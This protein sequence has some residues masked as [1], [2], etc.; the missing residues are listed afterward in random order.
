MIPRAAALGFLGAAMLVAGCRASRRGPE[1]EPRPAPRTPV[2]TG[3]RP[4]APPDTASLRALADS[5]RRA[6]ERAESLLVG[7]PGGQ[8]GTTPGAPA[9]A[10]SEAPAQRCVLDLENRDGTGAMMVKNPV[11]GR[12]YTVIGGGVV[13]R[14]RGQ[15]VTI[16]ADS[17]E[18]YEDSRLYLLIGNVKYREPKLALDAQRATYFRAEERILLENAVHA[19]MLQGGGTLDGSRAEYWRPARGIRER[20]RLVAYNR[21]RLT[22]VEHDSAGRPLPPVLL[23]ADVIIGEGDSTFFGIGQVEITRQDIFARAD[24]AMMDGNRQFSRLMKKPMIE[25]RGAQPYTLRGEV[26]DLFGSARQVERVVAK[27]SARAESKQFTVQSDTIDL[28]VQGSRLNRAFAFGSAGAIATTPE[29]NIVADSLDIIMP[30]QRIRELRAIGKA[31]AESDPDSTKVRSVERDWL[32]GDTVIARFDSVAAGDT[33]RPALQSLYAAGTA[34]AIY[35]IPS[36]NG[37]LDRPGINYIRGNVIRLMF[38]DGEVETVHVNGNAS[39][40]YLE[41]AA[42]SAARARPSRPPAPRGRTP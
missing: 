1:P 4:S 5:L 41:P 40:V 27:D 23:D 35:Q 30:G 9:G 16:E 34:S 32:R 10:P 7:R 13:G 29:R 38:A 42:D 33:S 2:D 3:V 21:P 15:Q 6:R 31:F 19:E 26:I 22:Y 36:N 28:R 12:Y 17:A 11:T 8:P 37:Q 14:C 24:S 39:G 18:G 20:P 25:S